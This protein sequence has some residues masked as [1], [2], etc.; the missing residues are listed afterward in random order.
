MTEITVEGMER[1]EKLLAGFPKGAE[2]AFSN[3][4]N[5]ALTHTKTQAFQEV[6]KVYSINRRE[7]NSNTSTRIKKAGVGDVIG[8]VEFSGAKLPLYKFNASPKTP[9]KGKRV[10]AGILRGNWVDFAHAFIAKLHSS[11][12]TGIFERDGEERYPISEIMGLSSA[13][14]LEREEVINNLSKEAKEKALERAEHEIDRIL[15][16]YGW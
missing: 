10:K 12:H 14:M 7:F 9:E 4:I 6:Q 1:A 2:R 16:G 15:S 11:G 3:A 13:Q 5:R 8:V